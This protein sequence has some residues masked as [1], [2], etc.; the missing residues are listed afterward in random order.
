M[1]SDAIIPE[2]PQSSATSET[3]PIA[4]NG[5]A[6]LSID[7]RI[8]SSPSADTG[9][10]PSSSSMTLLRRSSSWRT[11]PKMETSR[12]VSGKSEKSTRN[13]IA[14]AYCGQRSRNMSSTARGSARTNPC[15]TSS[16]ARK[17]RVRSGSWSATSG[18]PIERSL[19]RGS[20]AA[21]GRSRLADD[22]ARLCGRG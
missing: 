18:A 9:S 12:I 7:C 22:D 14:A 19:R 13:E 21:R 1:R 2:A 15:A 17:K 5:E 4:E 8:S 20:G 16:G 3:R 11:S 6:R 10:T